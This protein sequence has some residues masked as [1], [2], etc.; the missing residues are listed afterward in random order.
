V[1]ASAV[2]GV[3]VDIRAIADEFAARGFIV[4]APDL[5]WRSIPGPIARYDDR[6]AQRSQP[7]LQ[8]IKIGERD[9][10]DTLAYL[11]TLPQF[12]GRAVAIG[13]CY[14]GPYAITLAKIETVFSLIVGRI[15]RMRSE[16][17]C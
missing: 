10:A 7:R 17:S 1:L 3:D 4:A 12:N 15:V 9:I 5:F 2:H 13:L 6:A 14:E 8:K 16:N 11:G